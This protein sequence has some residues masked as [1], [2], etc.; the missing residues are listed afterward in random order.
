MFIQP[1][2]MTALIRLGGINDIDL[3]NSAVMVFRKEHKGLSPAGSYERD[4]IYISNGS[5]KRDSV[6]VPRFRNPDGTTFAVLS[7]IMIPG[8]S[9]SIR[10]VIHILYKYLTKDESTSL[11][12]LCDHFEISISTLY[13]WIHLFESQYALWTY[14]LLNAQKLC[15][16]MLSRILAI[17]AFPMLFLKTFKQPFLKPG[18]ISDPSRLLLPP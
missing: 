16:D 4:L 8:S 9:H 15:S 14:S 2:V 3:Y 11:A 1:S 18:I 7:D 10:Y 12:V 17:P 6:I 5:R 13:E